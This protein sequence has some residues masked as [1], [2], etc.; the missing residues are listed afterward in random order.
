MSQM[1]ARYRIVETPEEPV[2]PARAFLPLQL[3]SAAEATGGLI[4]NGLAGRATS[5]LIDETGALH[6]EIAPLAL[7]Y[8]AALVSGLTPDEVKTL[9]R[10]LARVETAALK[11]SGRA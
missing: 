9:R 7:A 6:R 1:A 11:L 3:A 10:L 4:A 5:P 8:E 2:V